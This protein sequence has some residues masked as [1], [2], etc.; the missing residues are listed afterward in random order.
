[1]V[2]AERVTIRSAFTPAL[3]VCATILTLCPHGSSRAQSAEQL[4]TT[5]DLSISQ[6]DAERAEQESTIRVRYFTLLDEYIQYAQKKGLLEPMLWARNE[7]ARYEQSPIITVSEDPKIPTK[8]K[9]TQ[10]ELKR[11]SDLVL[12]GWEQKYLDATHS[13][14]RQLEGQIKTLT[15]QGQLEHALT[16]RKV[17]QRISESA[18]YRTAQAH[19]NAYQ[20]GKQDELL[21]LD[22][23]R[24]EVVLFED[25]FRGTT[26]G[27]HWKSNMSDLNISDGKLLAPS[28]STD[29]DLNKNFEGNF[30]I[31]ADIMR[32]G[33]ANH[34]G[35]DFGLVL[36]GI[37]DAKTS[38]LFAGNQLRKFTLGSDVIDLPKD[39]EV[40]QPG[41]YTLTHVNGKIRATYRDVYGQEITT[42]W[43][44]IGAF[45]IT[46]LRIQLAGHGPDAP[47]C[48]DNLRAVSIP[49]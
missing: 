18:T 19:F 42:A 45:D 46:Q 11:A 20:A 27:E 44:S 34:S 4:H 2:R 49:D 35:W 14:F 47:R 37:D 39:S 22:S 13:Y 8:V 30:R 21:R 43:K 25:D 26:L 31:E 33:D 29:L 12:I 16:L 3:L 36:R 48:V 32:F 6:I 1:M 38:I 23:R 24:R 41:K 9:R 40:V 15:T 7:K 17:S 10:H 28:N 5:Y